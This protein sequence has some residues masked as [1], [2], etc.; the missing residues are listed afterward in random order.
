MTEQA[1]END[2]E[3]SQN[4]YLTP[5]AN[6]HIPK[7]LAMA[8]YLGGIALELSP[9]NFAVFAVAKE[10]LHNPSLSAVAFTAATFL[11]EA[12]GVVG[13]VPL[14]KSEIAHKPLVW[15]KD[16]LISLGSLGVM[17][18]GIL[19]KPLEWAQRKADK[20]GVSDV[21]TGMISDLLIGLAAGTVAL[22]IAKE[23][24]NPDREIRSSISYGLKIAL[25]V[26]AISGAGSLAAAEGLQHPS[27]TSYLLAALG[28]GFFIGI[29]Y[30]TKR[31]VLRAKPVLNSQEA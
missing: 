12:A 27:T 4:N 11:C 17:R 5:E 15:A 14:L 20:L 8:A 18:S 9:A 26:S 28:T 25:G 22:N 31:V 24:Q 3:I 29:K 16:K 21:K 19:Q 7:R 30:L 1:F 2:P 13:S 23:K 10:S 6:S